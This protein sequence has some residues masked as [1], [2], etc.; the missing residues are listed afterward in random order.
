VKRFLLRGV[1][2]LLA[3]AVLA[4][5]ALKIFLPTDRL[6]ALAAERLQA[7]TGAEVAYGDV[8]LDLWPRVAVRVADV[9]LR[10][11]APRPGAPGVE[12]WRLRV[13]ELRGGLALAP[14]LRRRAELDRVRLLRPVIEVTTRP[15]AAASAAAGGGAGVGKGA[16][17]VLVAAGAEVE[18]GAVVWRERG[19]REVRLTGWHQ[20]V[21]ATELTRLAALLAAWAGAGPAP[22]DG[23]P[24]E[25]RLR[26]RAAAMTLAGVRPGEPLI[27]EDLALSGRLVAPAAGTELELRDLEAAWGGVRLSGTGVV[28]RPGPD[29]RLELDWRLEELDA[30]E[31]QPAVAALLPPGQ[32]ALAAWLA[33][34]P[35]RI[36][37]VQADG[38]FVLPL[39]MP[40]GPAAATVLRGLTAQ[41]RLRD[42]R[43]TPP[44]LERA[45]TVDAEINLAEAQLQVRD[46]RAVVGEGELT[47][48]LTVGHVGRPQPHASVDAQFAGLPAA[49]V[50]TAL[51][52]SAAPYLEGAADGAVRGRFRLGD[53]VVLRRSLTLSGEAVLSDGVIHAAE[54]LEGVSPYLGDRQDLKD[55]VYG[56]L[57]HRL[58]VADGRY[59][60]RDL[61]L[62]GRD[63]D[64]SGGGWLGLDGAIDLRL[65]A[66][67]P[68]GFTPDLGAMS[69][70]AEALRDADG[71]LT[72]D[73]TLTGR[74]SRPTVGLDLGSAGELLQGSSR[75][76][77]EG[78]RGEAVLKGVQGLLDKF[79][80][81]R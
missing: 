76:A 28:T 45:W 51:A 44:R 64:W 74:A 58:E 52:P 75:S 63:T 34:A 49:E 3:A 1:A 43:V 18:D 24:G 59:H 62:R 2:A 69:L 73:L 25:L 33:D 32:A 78:E 80:K 10:G 36:P 14:L 35:C 9:D 38:R 37:D 23:G 55:I 30:A 22:A 54:W 39:P 68:P 6:A 4:V 31:A 79:R 50:L 17:V 56:S 20:E 57:R 40:D 11:L 7:A 71:R 47:G 70:L 53:A 46:V 72:L 81:R 26:G 48:T 65:R 19:G 77:L 8:S 5:V 12:T 42:A 61:D 41:A 29:G 60:I 16:P 15:A 66:K 27:L 13:A 67:L 21:Q